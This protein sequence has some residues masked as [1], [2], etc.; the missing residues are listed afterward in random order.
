MIEIE[1]I[2]GE[3][4]NYYQITKFGR[5]AGELHQNFGVWEY[6]LPSDGYAVSLSVSNLQ[7]IINKLNELNS[8]HNVNN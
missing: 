8:W 4:Y 1:F 5:D 2:E 7:Q 3:K 6:E